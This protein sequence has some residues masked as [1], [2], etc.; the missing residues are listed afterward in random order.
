MF[1]IERFNLKKLNCAVV[2][3][4]FQVKISKK[5]LALENLD[6]NVRNQEGEK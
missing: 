4:K 6:D 3:E 2:K 1:D 5:C